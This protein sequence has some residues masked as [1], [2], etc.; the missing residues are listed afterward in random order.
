L[1]EDSDA[2]RRRWN[3]D[4]EPHWEIKFRPPPQPSQ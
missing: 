4:H 2:N 3:R 1:I